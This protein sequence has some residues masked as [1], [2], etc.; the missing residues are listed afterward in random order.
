MRMKKKDKPFDCVAMKRAGAAR[1]RELTKDMTF[2]ERVEFWRKETELLLAEQKV[3]KEK[4]ERRESLA[5]P[6]DG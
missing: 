5:Q 1:I 3:A 4:A 2:E 6:A